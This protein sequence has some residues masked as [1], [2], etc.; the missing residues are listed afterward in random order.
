MIKIRT[1]E[2]AGF[3]GALN[4][5]RLPFGKEFPSGSDWLRHARW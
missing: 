2:I 5:L 4:A 1:L 3:A